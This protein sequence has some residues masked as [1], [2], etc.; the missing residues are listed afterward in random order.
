MG[1]T[2]RQ[3]AGHTTPSTPSEFTKNVQKY[4]LMFFTSSGKKKGLGTHDMF[5]LNSC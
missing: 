4:I 1:V 3:I 2:R 5:L